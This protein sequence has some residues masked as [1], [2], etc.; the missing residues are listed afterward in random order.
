MTKIFFKQ[1][2][3]LNNVFVQRV[4]KR[5]IRSILI[6]MQEN[7]I[8]QKDSPKKVRQDSIK[9]RNLHFVVRLPVTR[10]K[11]SAIGSPHYTSLSKWK[12]K[13]FHRT[14]KNILDL[15]NYTIN[16]A[17]L[18]ICIWQGWISSK[19]RCFHMVSNDSER[20]AKLYY[21]YC[22]ITMGWNLIVEHLR[23]VIACLAFSH[24]R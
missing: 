10:L 9:H 17:S 2:R 3:L 1:Y 13:D 5:V 6:S 7:D 16:F 19:V 18:N 24:S 23:P 22:T 8:N 12:W 20:A 11:K 4:E 21:R 14:Q 15:L